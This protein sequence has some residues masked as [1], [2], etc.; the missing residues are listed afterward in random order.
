MS[1]AS[2]TCSQMTLFDTGSAISSPASAGGLLLPDSPDGPMIGKSG[3]AAPPA[4]R[5]RSPASSAVM[6]TSGTYGPSYSACSVPEGPLSSWENRLRQ[7]LAR[8]GSTE[9]ALTWKESVT[10]AGQSLCRLVP[11]TRPIEGTDCGLW[12]TP[13]ARDWKD[14]PGMAQEGADGRNRIDQLPRQVAAAMWPTATLGDSRNSRNAT[15]SRSDPDSQH[16]S[17][18]TLSDHAHA[19]AMWPTPTTPSGGQGWPEGTTITGRRPNGTKATVTLLQVV[20]HLGTTPDGSSDTTAK[21]GALAPEFVS[22][23]MGFPPSWL[24]CAP[25][26]MPKKAKSK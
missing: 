22:W 26:T 3:Q 21:R 17:G 2:L 12:V 13:S 19:M 20:G 9:C 14:S 7:R 25:T 5:S 1:A 10:P 4:S 11:S 15:V 18:W 8:I 6:M 24:D 23:L 16:H